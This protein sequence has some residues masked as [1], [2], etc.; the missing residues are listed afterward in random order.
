MTLPRR[1]YLTVQPRISG[2]ISGSGPITTQ[3]SGRDWTIGFNASS[4]GNIAVPANARVVA[5]DVSGGVPGHVTLSQITAGVES[6]ISAIETALTGKADTAHTHVI[7]NVANLQSTLDGLQG[8]LDGLQTNKAP[9]SIG[10]N[11]LSDVDTVSSPPTSG[12]ALAYNGS[13]WVPTSI[14]AASSRLVARKTAEYN[15]NVDLSTII[16]VDD[17]VPQN[18]E[19]A[20][21]LSITH[22]ASAAGN[23]I[24]LRFSGVPTASAASVIAAAMFKSGSSD[25]ISATM[26]EVSVAGVRAQMC[27]ESEVTAA[28]TSSQTYSVRVG[29]GSGGINVRFN[30]TNTERRFG[31]SM[32]ATLILEEIIP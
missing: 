11:Y 20:E 3:R 28:T 8:G 15:L 4:L 25:A 18:T 29:P 1:I 12:Q 5:Y 26:T 23:L 2:L 19:G 22:A 31:G 21:I 6:D 14:G 9:A 27:M 10:L 16:P 32:K 30:G 24:R 13:N 17:T 7:G